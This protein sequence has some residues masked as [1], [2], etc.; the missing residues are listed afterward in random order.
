MAP[1]SPNT[2]LKPSKIQPLVQRNGNRGS[3]F[4]VLLESGWMFQSRCSRTEFDL[5]CK[6]TSRALEDES[7]GSYW[8]ESGFH[9]CNW[10]NVAV[11][12]T[13]LPLSPFELHSFIPSFDAFL[14]NSPVTFYHVHLLPTFHT[15]LPSFL[16]YITPHPQSH[17]PALGC[18]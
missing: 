14:P 10:I 6:M 17:L 8:V 15:T 1:L 16:P 2:S 12:D 3:I 18:S 11:S 13:P 7:C 4:S 5:L 9:F